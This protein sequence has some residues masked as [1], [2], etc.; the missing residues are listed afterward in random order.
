MKVLITGV[1]SGIGWG[2][3]NYYLSKGH[4][5]FGLSR[6]IPKQFINSEN[7]HHLS[8]DLS[9]IDNIESN[10]SQF[11]TISNTIDLVILNAGI[12]GPIDDLKNQSI[13]NIKSVMDINVWS[14]KVL[15]DVLIKSLENI[16][17]VVAIS[18]GA[19]VNGSRGWGGYS[20]SKASLNML[21][22]LYASE[23]E[24]TKFYAFA[25]GLVD[26]K[27]QDIL[28]S[29]KIDV[30]TFPASQKLIDARYTDKMPSAEKAG[31]ILANAIS[32]LDSF[33]SGSFVDIRTME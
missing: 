11:I 26:T 4:T 3:T 2:L 13:D 12:L 27:M 9:D 8:I 29:G 6:R 25:P 19:S 18:S 15:I 22:K 20:I 24:L 16:N 30:N 1:S 7:F 10:S 5:V 33:P 14:N 21:I 23:N 28:C 17:S 31:E 32:K